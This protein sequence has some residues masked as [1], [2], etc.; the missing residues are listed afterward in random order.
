MAEVICSR[1]LSTTV[2]A[3]TGVSPSYVREGHVVFR[4][5]SGAL[6]SLSAMFEIGRI[7]DQYWMI[8]DT[9]SA[10]NEKMIASFFDDLAS[11]YG[12]IIDP[13]RNADNVRHLLWLLLDHLKVSGGVFLDLGCGPGAS[14]AQVEARGQSVV[15]VDLSPR[16]RILAADSGMVTLTPLQLEASQPGSFAGGFASYVLHLDPRPDGLRRV[17]STFLPGGALVANVH[18]DHG[19]EILCEYIESEGCSW[20]RLPP[21]V[22]DIHGSYLA[23]ID[24]S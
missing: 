18:K 17:L 1:P 9:D 23:V 4:V 8:T 20:K 24:R 10:N 11:D 13:G 14:R 2:K 15:G 16:M 7:L 6:S 22:L 5:P 19:L 3:T 12:N 21:P